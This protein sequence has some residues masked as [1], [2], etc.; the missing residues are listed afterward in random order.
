ML[1]G[2]MPWNRIDPYQVKHRLVSKGESLQVP[3]PLEE[4]HEIYDML[5]PPTLER[6]LK[7][8]LARQASKRMKSMQQLSSVL[9]R[10]IIVLEEEESIENQP[11]FEYQDNPNFE[12]STKA[13]GFGNL[14]MYNH[15]YTLGE[16][17]L[18]S[19]T[20]SKTILESSNENVN[21]LIKHA[22]GRVPSSGNLP[23][24]RSVKVLSNPNSSSSAGNWSTA[25]T[26]MSALN[27]FRRITKYTESSTLEKSNTQVVLNQTDFDDVH[28][29]ADDLR[30]EVDPDHVEKISQGYQDIDS[31]AFSEKNV[32]IQDPDFSTK[33]SCTDI[34]LEPHIDRFE[35]DSEVKT[36]TGSNDSLNVEIHA[37]KIDEIE[38]MEKKIRQKSSPK[39]KV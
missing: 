26:K 33:S 35:T 11:K 8:G 20:A 15:D 6:L 13:D 31:D 16:S 39:M 30:H 5:L 28:R 14:T 1:A 7:H 22:R 32:K 21:E 23:P 9:K 3:P 10:L 36:L 17:I 37:P 38:K 2:I 27:N 34:E 19:P 24:Q 18:E 29:V 12:Q 25:R 4:D